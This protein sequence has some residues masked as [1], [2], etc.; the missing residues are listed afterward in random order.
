MADSIAPIS[1][2]LE[3]LTDQYRTITQNLANANTTGYKRR[4]TAFQQTLASQMTSASGAVAD[5]AVA[6]RTSID[7]TQ[8]AMA[9]T[10][11]PLDMAIDGAGFFVLETPTGPLYTRHGS[12]G[13]NSSNQLV[14]RAGRLVGGESGP[15]TIPPTVSLQHVSISSD[16]TVSAEGKALGKVKLVQFKD[17]SVLTPVGGNCYAAPSGAQQQPAKASLCQGYQ[18]GSNVN[19]VEEMVGLITVS[20]LYEANLKNV[21][22][23]DERMKTLLGAVK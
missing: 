1:S 12:F 8:G 5:P 10:E 4:M 7:F 3:A 19:I 6:G 9:R 22:T 23:Q 11:S 2:S 16:G 14:D 21:H 20:R 13:L 15:I 18:E 17:P